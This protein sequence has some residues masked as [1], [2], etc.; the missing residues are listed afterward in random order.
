MTIKEVCETYNISADT[1]RYY[2][3]VGVIP[4]V[5]RTA[6]GIRDYQESDIGWVQ[7]AICLWD[8]G[9]PVE[10]I[11]EYVKLYQE[12]DETFAAR[13]DLLLQAKEGILEARSKYDRALKRLN[14]KIGCYDRAVLTGQLIWDE[15]EKD[16]Q[17]S[18]GGGI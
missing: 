1:L 8:A 15:E 12:G 6:G 10:L 9:V 18:A 2:E 4:E 17:E 14:Y 7:N 13:R 16:E 11:V 5:H 3:R